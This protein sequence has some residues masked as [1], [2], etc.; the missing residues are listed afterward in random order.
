MSA[1]P[2]DVLVSKFYPDATAEY[3]STLAPDI[4]R[5]RDA[6]GLSAEDAEA[7]LV[8]TAEAFQDA[9]ISSRD[10]ARLHSL[11]T[12]RTVTPADAVTVD[13]RRPRRCG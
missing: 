5:L 3:R 8:A 9:G 13:R 1:N 4:A 2:D 6:S 11:I 7:R 12:A 10:A